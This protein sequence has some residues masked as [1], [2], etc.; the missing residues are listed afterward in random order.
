MDAQGLTR[1]ARAHGRYRA[2]IPDVLSDRPILLSGLTSADVADAERAITRLDATATALTDTEGIARLLLRAESVASSRIE[3]LQVPARRLLRADYA[4]GTNIQQRDDTA[5]E[6][7]GNIDAMA[8]A[9]AEVSRGTPISRGLLLKTHRLLLEHAKP[10]YA[11]RTRD[12]Q[13]WIGGNY[14]NPMGAD[15]VP[16]PPDKVDALLDDLCTF[17]NSDDLPAVAQAAIAH[18]QFETIHPFID[19]NGCIGRVLIHLILR[20]RKLAASVLPPV[21]LIL[22]TRADAYIAALAG[23]RYVGSPDSHEAQEGIDTWIGTFAAACTRAV[24]DALAFEKRISDLQASWR[25]RLGT[26]RADSATD[27]LVAALP[28]SPV[29]SLSALTPRLSRSLPRVTEA[30]N[31]FVEAEIL[32]EV[33]V[34]RQR[35]QVYEASEVIDAFTSLERGLASITGETKTQP[36]VRAVP[37][38]QQMT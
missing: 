15:F 22:A 19:G 25:K 34:G 2:Y 1:R 11:G 32:S 14:Y 10:Q 35:G 29:T 17:A 31:R 37:A 30:V 5:L 4:R 33:N 20:R 27:L 21:S 24:D 9:I 23:T 38:R 26:I 12:V 7:L 18:A 16:P 36:P 3:G 28:G 6:I 8:Y 13:N